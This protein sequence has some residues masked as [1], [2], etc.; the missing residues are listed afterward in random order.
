MMSGAD[1]WVSLEFRVCRELAG[2]EDNKLRFLWCD[3]FIPEE[4][5]LQATKPC[6]RGRAWIGQVK[7]SPQEQWAFTLFVG[8]ARSE[9]EIDWSALL[10][11]DDMTGWLTPDLRAKTLTLDPLSAYL[12]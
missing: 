3:G 10:P 11:G 7:R 8:Q 6:I 9:D 12:G 2:F 5:D 4:A 1:Y